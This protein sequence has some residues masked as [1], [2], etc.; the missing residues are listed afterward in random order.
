MLLKVQ[1]TE[2]SINREYGK[3]ELKGSVYEFE[4]NC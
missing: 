1:H 3:M 4:S 2:E